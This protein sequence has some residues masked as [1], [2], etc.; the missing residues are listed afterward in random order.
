MTRQNYNNTK[1]Y[2]TYI[3]QTRKRFSLKTERMDGHALGGARGL[4][5]RRQATGGVWG[6]AQ[7]RDQLRRVTD[8][9]RGPRGT[10]RRTGISD[11]QRARHVRSNGRPKGTQPIVT[12]YIPEVLNPDGQLII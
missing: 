9:V 8:M 4:P 10:Q 11:D 1:I 6:F 5:E 2:T 3:L 7:G 12:L